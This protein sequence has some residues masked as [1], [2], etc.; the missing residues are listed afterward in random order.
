MAQIK[1][2][3]LDSNQ[4]ILP[5]AKLKVLSRNMD[6]GLHRWVSDTCHLKQRNWD[7]DLVPCQTEAVGGNNKKRSLHQ[8]QSQSQSLVLCSE[9]LSAA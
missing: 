4:K 3:N 2:R 1:G 8:L 5:S 6:T 9:H 7:I